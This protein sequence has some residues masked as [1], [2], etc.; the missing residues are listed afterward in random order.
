MKRWISILLTFVLLTG[1][2]AAC[3]QEEPVPGNRLGLDILAMMTDGT[4]NAFVSPVSLAYAL[5]MAAYGAQGAS[6]EEILLA[7]DASDASFVST[8]NE[9]LTESGLKIANAAFVQDGFPIKEAY[10]EGIG[11]LCGARLFPLDA[12]ETVNAWVTEHTDGLIPKLLEEGAA[13]EADLL[14]VNAIAMDARWYK[15]FDRYYTSE[16]V[17]HAPQGDVRVDFM[18]NT[19]ETDYAEA[20]G[21]QAVKLYY[22]EGGL[23]MM[24]ILPEEGGLGDLLC[25]L[26]EQGPGLFT[27]EERSAES[28]I[29]GI[30]E[31]EKSYNPDMDVEAA[32][33]EI[34]YYIR[35]SEPWKV[36]LRLPKLDISTSASL[37]GPLM[38]LGVGAPFSDEA[39]FSGISDSSLLVTDVIQKV[40]VQVDEEGTRAAAISAIVLNCTAVQYEQEP[41]SM[42]L[43]RP[44]I[45]LIADEVTGAICFAGVVADPS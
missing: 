42:V 27:F 25:L 45:L 18:R 32:R 5:S 35:G 23:Y 22:Q 34:S 12:A 30:I 7:L 21:A 15:P 39:D 16:D 17:F 6:S 24:L 10:T 19:L 37:K 3:A 11:S 4:K 29:D 41:V 14:L 31:K 36:S 43:D 44:F 2:C 20:E 13:P 33:E 28:I 9:P 26:A 1:I 40:R 8:W 38:E